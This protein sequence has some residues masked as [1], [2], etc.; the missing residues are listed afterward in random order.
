MQPRSWRNDLKFYDCS[1]APSPRRVR[2]F[3]AEKKIE[4]E[5]VEV[6]LRS[7]EHLNDEYRAINPDCVVPA[8]QL[9][10]GRFLTE[11][12]AICHY[13]EELHPEPNLFGT[14]P[15]ERG[16]VLEWNAKVEQQ[17]LLSMMD[18]LRNASKGMADRALTGP[19]NYAQIPALAERG[20]ARVMQFFQRIDSHLADNQYLAGT[21]FT[22]ADITAFVLVDFAAWV[23]LGLPDEAEHARRWYESVSGR[24]STRV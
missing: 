5:T 7:G 6:D 24:D 11:S 21:R 20:R 23:K 15:E 12:L 22:L 17:G 18:A 2:I 10:N 16:R 4:L 8:L 9:D 3:M 1:T 13:L 14:T 19:V